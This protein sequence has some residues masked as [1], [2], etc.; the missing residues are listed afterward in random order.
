MLRALPQHFRSCTAPSH[1]PMQRRRRP[2]HCFANAAGATQSARRAQ[3]EKLFRI[4]SKVPLT[5]C[6][7]CPI[8]PPTHDGQT[9]ASKRT[10]HGRPQKFAPRDKPNGTLLKASGRFASSVCKKQSSAKSTLRSHVVRSPTSEAMLRSLATFA[11]VSAARK[12]A[13]ALATHSRRRSGPTH[14]N[15]V[16]PPQ[17]SL[18]PIAPGKV[19]RPLPPWD[20]GFSGSFFYAPRC[21]WL[22]AVSYR[23][24]ARGRVLNGSR[25]TSFS[26]SGR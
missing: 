25:V 14:L 23:L 15:C 6:G 9:T 16:R 19:S 20:V 5:R 11:A 26:S 22:S 13:L 2:K 1:Y 3:Q 24:S 4:S 21:G 10:R 12:L 7:D 8:L 18:R 17:A